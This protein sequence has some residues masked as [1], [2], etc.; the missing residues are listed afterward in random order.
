MPASC[1]PDL[2]PIRKEFRTSNGCRAF[3]GSSWNVISLFRSI[4]RDALRFLHR[5]DLR[6][7]RSVL[8]DL[9]SQ[10]D[11]HHPEPCFLLL[12]WGVLLGIH[13]GNWAKAAG[14]IHP[15]QEPGIPYKAAI[16][17]ACRCRSLWQVYR[18]HIPVFWVFYLY[19][20]GRYHRCRC[21]CSLGN[22]LWS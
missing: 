21:C 20:T 22:A 1:S 10:K 4:W 12:E 13:R 3:Y 7:G 14:Q 16:R 2:Y 5:W 18:I 17:R 15:A 8:H 6:A 19:D 11:F 9:I